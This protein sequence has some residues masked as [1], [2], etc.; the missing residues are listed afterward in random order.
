MC[1]G[2]LC[3]SVP[4]FLAWGFHPQGDLLVQSGCCC[5]SHHISPVGEKWE[6]GVMGSNTCQLSIPLCRDFLKGLPMRFLSLFIGR[7][8]LPGRLG[9]GVF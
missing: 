9:N 5:T 3:L 7:P 1:S 6:E 8:Q 2:L 4:P